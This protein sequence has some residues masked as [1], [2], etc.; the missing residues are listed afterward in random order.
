MSAMSQLS[1]ADGDNAYRCTQLL[2][3]GKHESPAT[4]WTPKPI[5]SEALGYRTKNPSMDFLPLRHR[6]T[7]QYAQSVAAHRVQAAHGAAAYVSSYAFL[8]HVESEDECAD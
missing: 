3:V 2:C 6:A 1:A 4:M 7:E 8:T 5:V